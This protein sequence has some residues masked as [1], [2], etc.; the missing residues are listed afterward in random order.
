MGKENRNVWLVADTH[1]F[2]KNIIDYCDR[3]WD[4]VYAMN[5]SLIK[6][7]NGVVK[8]GD[9]VYVLGDFALG[10]KDMIISAG[11]SLNGDKRLILGNHDRAS[12]QTYYDAGF[13][14][15]Y[16]HPIIIDD[17]FILSHRP[18]EF[19][20]QDGV[21]AN[22]YGHVHNDQRFQTCTPRSYCVSVERTSYLPVSFEYV[23]QKMKEAK[24]GE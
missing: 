22:I 3:P 21:F 20:P 24:N 11:R 15:V 14:R 23:K 1:F 4:D 5:N 8:K 7:W 13:T 2:H 17:F 12:M 18:I 16:D 9:V 10:T 19:L 6:N